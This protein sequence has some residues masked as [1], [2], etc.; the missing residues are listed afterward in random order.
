MNNLLIALIIGLVAGTIDV[1]PMLI[2]KLD[3]ISNLSAFFHYFALGIIIS[4]VDFGI[5]PVLTGIIVSILVAI[6]VMIIVFPK[7]K[8][9]LIPMTVFA[10]GLGAAIGWAGSRFIVG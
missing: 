10:I 5:S 1:I 4:F 6:P 8:K 9:A 2:M 3:K 7:D